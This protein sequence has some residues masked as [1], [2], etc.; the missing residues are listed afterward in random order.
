MIFKVY[1]NL[2][3]IYQNDE[4]NLSIG[5]ELMATCLAECKHYRR[6][7]AY[8]SSSS[9]KT[10]A[11]FLGDIIEKDVKIEILCSPVIQDQ[12]LREILSNNSSK[13][14]KHA[15]YLK[16]AKD[17]LLSA[18]GFSEDP[19]NI[20][21]RS[22]ILSYLISKDQLEIKF[23][24]PNG[25][26]EAVGN[27]FDY[28]SLYHVKN[29]YFDFPNGDK[30]AF[31]GSF[32]ES[33]RGHLTNRERT[34]V[35]RSWHAE[36]KGRLE[37]TV[38]DIDRD[39]DEKSSDLDIYPLGEEILL[40]IKKLAPKNKPLPD[41]DKP[42]NVKDNNVLD[43][44]DHQKEAIN[45]FIEKKHGILEMATGT[46]KTTTALEIVKRLYES[47]SIDSVIISTYGDTLLEQWALEVEEWKNKQAKDDGSRS[48]KDF[49]VF[50]DF[51]G[52]SEM[53]NYLNIVKDSIL[54]VSRSAKKLKKL[55]SSNQIKNHKKRTLIIHDE[56]HGF[57]SEGLSVSLEG[58]HQDI[59]YSLGLSATPARE[60]GDGTSFIISEIGPVIFSYE[61][62][63]AIR[64]GILCE[65]NY[66]PI[67]FE[68][69]KKDKEKIRNIHSRAANSA[70]EGN[71][72]A[73]DRLYRELS[74]V[75][76][77]A[78]NKIQL[79]DGFLSRNE[80]LIKST[81]LFAED[82]PHGD[83]I[84]R[85]VG[86]YTQDYSTF[87]QGAPAKFV[88]YLADGAN[89]GGVDALI[90]C[91]RLNEGVDIKSLKNIFLIST[92][93]TK[94]ITVQRMGRCLRIDPE[95][96]AKI[97]NIIDFILVDNKLDSEHIPTDQLRKQWIE[98]LSQVKRERNASNN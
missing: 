95:N 67:D 42:T 65:F 18:A 58:S 2:K 92:P 97:A 6:G 60:Y 28:E 50:R 26:E 51:K 54:I 35:F 80:E 94:L 4:H 74:I 75:R 93:R 64:D 86:K 5:K 46:G 23:A 13:E 48:V 84:A 59:G 38:N 44:W 55:L 40:K 88:K 34:N 10:Y 17:I 11:S 37:R 45:V 33:S 25:Y 7:T 63:D 89:K 16:S 20:E 91:R 22:Q 81:V 98:K 32:N 27:G 96:P 73:D 61:T 8:F 36:D 30:V 79:L 15:E 77:K 57:G 83:K 19:N 72:W 1:R 76:K 49:Y 31:D 29:G 90:A 66:Y 87:Y 3:D 70:K 14:K 71:P 52:N 69:T 43:L 82:K 85:I 53:M 24:I 56:V 41:I 62:D 78:E 39:W 21:Y 47:K 68:Y 9:L 12:K